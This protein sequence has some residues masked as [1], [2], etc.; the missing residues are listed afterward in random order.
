MV[1]W[2]ITLP[3]VSTWFL[4]TVASCS[5]AGAPITLVMP[6]DTWFVNALAV[7]INELTLQPLDQPPQL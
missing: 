4:S 3:L 6:W 7:D 5:G 1:K 2:I